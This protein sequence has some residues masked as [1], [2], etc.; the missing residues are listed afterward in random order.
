MMKPEVVPRE[1]KEKKKRM[2]DNL[3]RKGQVF[4]D[5]QK[6]KLKHKKP[7]I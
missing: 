2:A 1:W 4:F 6:S 3:M 7:Y 5:L